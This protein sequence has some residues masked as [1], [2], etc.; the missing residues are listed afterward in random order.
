MNFKGNSALTMIVMA[1]IIFGALFFVDYENHN[2]LDG[3]PIE[4]TSC[5][6]PSCYDQ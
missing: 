3:W 5:P 2:N 1:M 6:T 4:Q